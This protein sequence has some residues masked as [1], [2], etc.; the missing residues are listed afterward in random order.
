MAISAEVIEPEYQA[1]VAVSVAPGSLA[2]GPWKSPFTLT[3]SV[4][5]DASLGVVTV[6]LTGRVTGPGGAVICESTTDAIVTLELSATLAADPTVIPAK[7]GW[8]SMPPWDI[9]DITVAWDPPDCEGTLEILDFVGDS[10]YTPPNKGTL[11]PDATKWG[12]TGFDEPPTELCPKAAN[13]PIAAM[14]GDTELARANVLVRPVH[15]WWTHGHKHGP[16]QV[17]H[18]P[19]TND[20]TN[21]YNFLRWKYANVLATTGGAF[22][23]VTISGSTY[24]TCGSVQFAAACTTPVLTSP[25]SFKV[26]FGT[27]AFLESENRAASIIGHELY[28]TTG[29]WPLPTNECPAYR[30]EAEH[31][32]GTGVCPCDGTYLSSVN[33]YLVG[34]SCP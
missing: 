21:D 2:C 5:P 15:T 18:T 7:T 11:A 22:S 25:G 20:F 10:G 27:Y 26:V 4:S 28:H 13:V 31:C 6:R 17:M 24:V 8:P 9:S 14:R 1:C 32:D 12:Y 16:G 30:W 33:D 29:T 19:D 23:S 3:V 34:N